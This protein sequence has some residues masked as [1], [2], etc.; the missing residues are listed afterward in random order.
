VH[1]VEL[2]LA[3]ATGLAAGTA[4]AAAPDLAVVA[5]VVL[6]AASLRAA[7]SRVA[8]FGIRVRIPG[9]AA[10]LL[11]LGSLLLH[12]RSQVPLARLAILAALGGLFA[13][14]GLVPFLQKI[15]HGEPGWT[16]PQAWTSFLGPLLAAVLFV[17]VRPLVP[18]G[19]ASAYASLLIGFGLLNV[20]WGLIGAWRSADEADARRDSL[21]AEWGLVLVG[22]GLIVPAGTQAAY[23]VL[24]SMLLVRL[25][26]QV[27][28]ASGASQPRPTSISNLLLVAALAGAAPFAGFPARILMFRA[29]TEFAWPLALVLLA[30][31]LLWLPQA[32]RLAAGFVPAPG[33]TAVG[34]GATLALSAIVGIFPSP[35]LR[36]AGL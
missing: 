8:P 16:S 32:L 28:S 10:M 36:L 15:D 26:L 35:F 12:S 33:R 14:I 30:G 29:A 1:R 34:L 31:F 21:L 2:L 23:L 11:V 22:L 20:F 17:R 9:L 3:G 6:A 13:A 4:I 5:L 19:A 24:L 7:A 25:P 18:A 27:W